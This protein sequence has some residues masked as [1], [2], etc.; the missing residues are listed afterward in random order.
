MH[1]KIQNNAYFLKEFGIDTEQ[2]KRLLEK[3]LSYGG[4]FADLYFEHSFDNYL[5]LEDGKVTRS[6]GDTMLGAGFRT[7]SG[8]RT[9][10]G[11]TEELTMGPMLSAAATA[12]TLCNMKQVKVNNTF[13]TPA[14]DR[15][16]AGS[17]GFTSFG[18]NEKLKILQELNKACFDLSPEILKVSAGFYHSVKRIL[19]VTSD[20]EYIEDFI[21]GS[22]LMASVVAERNKQR[23]QAGWNLGGKHDLTFY[24][25]QVIR[26]IAETA[27]LNAVSLFGA[28]QP[29]AGEFP[30]VLG[31]GVTGVLLHEA[32]GHGME[33]DFNR[34]NTSTYSGMLG[35][36]VAQPFVTIVDDATNP[37]L[38]GSINIDDEGTPGTKTVLVENGILTGYMHDKIS[39]EYYGVKPT[40]NGRRQDFQHYPMPRMRNTYMLNGDADPADVIKQ[41]GKGIYVENVSNGEVKIGEGDFSFYV[42][43]GRMIEG[44]KLTTTIKDINIIGNGPKMLADIVMVANDLEM[45]R[46]GSGMCGKNGQS[47]PV[48]FGEPT[49]LVKSLTVGGTAM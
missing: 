37:N 15:F 5:G 18:L 28:V 45:Y 47:V 6:Y 11:F 49:C 13:S 30:V 23:E 29:P 4:D 33:A 41:A 34:K 27:V 39:A 22:Y 19:I 9:G 20:G 36:K 7:V 35:K 25:Q 2:C 24:N 12:S 16:Y 31:P 42:S 3:A 38:A 17:S 1:K 48:S 8:D 10:Y 43:K 32:I 14:F 44:G 46:G 26:Q 40:G 21:P